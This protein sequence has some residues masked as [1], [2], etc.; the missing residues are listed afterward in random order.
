MVIVGTYVC[1]CYSNADDAMQK[2][3]TLQERGLLVPVGPVDAVVSDGDA[4]GIAG[5]VR[6]HPPRPPR[7]RETLCNAQT[8]RQTDRR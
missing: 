6:H 8:D 2:V 4:E 1:L 3:E 5:A 7:Q